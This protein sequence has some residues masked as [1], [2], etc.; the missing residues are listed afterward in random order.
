MFATRRYQELCFDSLVL[1]VPKWQKFPDKRIPKKDWIPH[2]RVIAVLS[3][4]NQRYLSALG[5]KSK[6]FFHPD[7]LKIFYLF[8]SIN[9]P[10]NNRIY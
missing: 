1:N 8:Q 3:E 2:S 5:A 10:K 9:Q 6:G 7:S 4:S